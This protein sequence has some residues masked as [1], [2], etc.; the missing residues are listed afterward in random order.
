V[1]HHT[2]ETLARVL[3][4]DLSGNVSLSVGCRH[5]YPAGATF[6]TA[7]AHGDC[8]GAV[9][10]LDYVATWTSDWDAG[11]DSFDARY[12]WVGHP[13]TLD[14]ESGIDGEWA[15]TNVSPG[16][17]QVVERALGGLGIFDVNSQD[18][19]PLNQRT[20]REYLVM[21]RAGF[22]QVSL[23]QYK[24]TVRFR[25]VTA[26]RKFWFFR[27]VSPSQPYTSSDQFAWEQRGNALP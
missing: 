21:P 12:D 19:A 13:I 2:V 9:R 7:I 11:G 25:T 16:R 15:V 20:G 14:S 3:D 24:Q 17:F 6:S 5:D 8:F 27:C 4:V 10:D 1:A 23:W 18:V 26:A 22:G